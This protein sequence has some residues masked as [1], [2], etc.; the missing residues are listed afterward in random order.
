[1][2]E[3]VGKEGRQRLSTLFFLEG[4]LHFHQASEQPV[5]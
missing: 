1:M 4:Q 2:Q 3:T 5:V